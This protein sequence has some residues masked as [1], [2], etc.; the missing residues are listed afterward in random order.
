MKTKDLNYWTEKMKE[1]V[2][3]TSNHLFI[4]KNEWIMKVIPFT[5]DEKDFVAI[6]SIKKDKC[7]MYIREIE[8]SSPNSLFLLKNSIFPKNDCNKSIKN[9][10]K[11]RLF[12][13]KAKALLEEKGKDAQVEI[14]K[15]SADIFIFEKEVV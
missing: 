1:Y 12:A 10:K 13:E 2:N 9:F 8:A 15:L 4:D 5:K 14:E 7:S 11:A 6:I 3:K